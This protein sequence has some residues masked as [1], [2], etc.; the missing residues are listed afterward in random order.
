MRGNVTIV[1][2]PGTGISDDKAVC[3]YVPDMIRFY[4]NEE[5]IIP[6]VPTY[7]CSKPKELQ[8]IIE[9]LETM[10]V[11]P[12]DMS[13]GYGVTI[14]DEL[15]KQEL[16]DIKEKI[17][18]NPRKFIAQPKIMLSTHA[19]YIEE[20]EMIE[21]RHIDLRTYS[22]MGADGHYVLN[23]GLTR[24]ALVRGNLIVNSSQ[25]GGSKDTWVLKNNGYVS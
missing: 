15:T 14:C 18:A 20:E 25:G 3:S 12:V 11:K 19:T 2:A 7:Q 10:V 24:T 21:P 17:K 9:N 6:N 1:N 8:H 4:L 16:A 22:I 13:G 5:P 23:G